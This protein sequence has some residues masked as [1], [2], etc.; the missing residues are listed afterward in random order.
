MALYVESSKYEIA[1][2]TRSPFSMIDPS[3]ILKDLQAGRDLPAETMRDVMDDLM[4]GVWPDE[5]IGEFL[6]ALARKGETA[7][8]LAAAAAVLR[9]HMTPIQHRYDRVLDT[10]GTGGDGTH[11]FNIST[12]SAFVV[13][14]AGVPVAKHG[15]RSVSSKSGSADVLRAL[16][17]GVDA[18]L[19]VVEEC[20]DQLG[21][22]FCFAPLWHPSV[23]HVAA[24]RRKLGVPTLFNWIGPLCNPAH[25]AHQALGVGRAGLRVKLAEALKTLG[26]VRSVVLHGSDG[27]DEVTLAT[28]THVSLVE[29]DRVSDM[30]WSFEDFDLPLVSLDS[31]KSTGVEESAATILGVIRGNAGPATEIVLANAA[32]ALWVF[33]IHPELTMCV[34]EARQVLNDGRAFE[35]L[36][37]LKRKTREAEGA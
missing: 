2:S 35:L 32:A 33:G 7:N 8:E 4:R 34:Q 25:A 37:E 29:G 6:L 10:C 1:H 11:T 19:P 17:V 20:L 36:Q 27:L 13:A 5:Q 22:C 28:Q 31:I 18:P 21:I 30:Q 24:V 9:S 23:R 26:T 15:N 16:G 12:A 3:P 14:A